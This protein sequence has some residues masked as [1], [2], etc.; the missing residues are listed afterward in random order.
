MLSIA[1]AP[2]AAQQTAAKPAAAKPAAAKPRRRQAL[3]A[4]RFHRP[5]RRPCCACRPGRRPTL[6]NGAE[7]I[8]SERHDLPLV[9]FSLIIIGGS[10]QFEAADRRGLASLTASM[11]S[12]GTKTR[13]GEALSNAMQLLGTTV[14]A[15]IGTEAGSMGFV[16]TSGKFAAALDLLADMLLNSTF[17]ADALERLRAQR[18]VA[19]TQ[20]RSQPGSIARNVFPRDDLWS[21]APVRVAS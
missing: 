6:A 19:L 21:G 13:D 5:A 16:S 15:G 8:V 3:T 11:L 17:P 4:R 2:M 12:E 18:L 7:L 14:G 10:A 1:F 20:A 9:S